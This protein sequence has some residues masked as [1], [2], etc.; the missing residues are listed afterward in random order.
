MLCWRFRGGLLRTLR[1]WLVFVVFAVVALWI[2]V[3]RGVERA[4]VPCM[5]EFVC[6]GGLLL[7]Y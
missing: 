4:M 7:R 5:C 1:P 2:C 6:L 3:M